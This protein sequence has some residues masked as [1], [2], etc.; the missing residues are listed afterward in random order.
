MKK[1]MAV[2]CGLVTCGLL[3]AD[4]GFVKKEGGIGF[5]YDD[6]R[7]VKMWK[8]VSDIFDK[9]GF[10]LMYAVNCRDDQSLS[11]DQ[12]VFL[13]E[14]AK[15]GHEIMDH[16]ALH[17]VFVFSA[18]DAAEYAGEP[19]VDHI[20]GQFVYV[21][22]IFRQDVPVRYA[23]E[24]IK[25]DFAG[26]KVTLP[27]EM[28]KKFQGSKLLKYQGKAYQVAPDRKNK[29][30][31]LVKS[32]WGEPVDM[33]NVRGA[34]VETADKNYS[35]S[36]PQEAMK[37]MGKIV[38]KRFEAMGLP[39]PTAWIQP[40]SPEAIIQADDVR[41]G[42]KDLGYTCAATYQDAALKVF[43]ETDPERC[44]YA[45]M[46]GQLHVG[47]PQEP[48]DFLKT[49]IA[50]GY[51]RHQ[52]LFA[53]SHMTD[54][55]LPGGWPEFLRKHDELLAWCRE[56]KIP[57]RTQSRWAELLYY[58]KTDPA[59]N[60]F[61]AW[62]VDLDGNQRPDGYKFLGQGVTINAAGELTAPN[63]GD[64]FEI[65]RL[66]GVEKGKNTLS[67]GVKSGSLSCDI[68]FWN[69]SRQVGSV[70]FSGNEKTFEVPAQAEYVNIRLVNSGKEPLVL[71]GA[72][73][74]QK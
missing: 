62:T 55:K 74:N 37:V 5:R 50:D 33:G 26:N 43:C 27:E 59:Q 24:K 73:L 32:F 57:V 66:G 64:V 2:F 11:A 44:A 10:P 31:F 13:R 42:L 21:K 48:V 68:T 12:Q 23:A 65:I 45:M 15:R 71:T 61:P 72:V 16:T 52:V 40:G 34:D 19:W 60:I 51:A 63:S 47:W 67:F 49:Q 28:H 9:Y 46:W 36:V 54:H 69:R 22:Y 6:N 18:P 7:T 25:V 1:I 53:S 58:S 39:R 3:A 70:R 4:T 35:F 41:K 8:E 20:K 17:R 29:G 14:L 30:V 38:L 56:K